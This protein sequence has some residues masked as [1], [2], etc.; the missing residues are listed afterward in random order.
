V[1]KKS[2]VCGKLAQLRERQTL[3]TQLAAKPREEFI[4]DP[5][6]RGA[7]ERLLHTSIEICL[8][9]GQHLIAALALPRPNEYRDIFRI[10]GERGILAADF[11]AR[12]QQMAAFRNRLVHLYAEVDPGTVYDFLQHDR[13]DFDA[14]ARVIAEFVRQSPERCE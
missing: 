10:L 8:D 14:F 7:A 1:I 5:L 6:T 2:L 11:A 4:A 12:L 9:V 3:L 13:A